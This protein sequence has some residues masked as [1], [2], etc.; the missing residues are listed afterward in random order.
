MVGKPFAAG[1]IVR[2]LGFP[3]QNTV[4]DIHIPGTGTRAVNP[5]SR[6]N[7]LVVLPAAAINIF[8]FS[9]PASGLD[10]FIC[11]R[12]LAAAMFFAAWSKKTK[13]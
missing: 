9:L 8:P 12:F 5:V 11:D 6:A 13:R 3:H 10:P 2:G 1:W 4:F 7:F